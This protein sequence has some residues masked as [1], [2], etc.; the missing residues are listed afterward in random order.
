MPGG[1]G[2]AES[3][4]WQ[5]APDMGISCRQAP[6]AKTRD[7]CLGTA[8]GRRVAS[9]MG[10]WSDLQDRGCIAQLSRTASP[11]PGCKR[12]RKTSRETG[13]CWWSPCPTS[14]DVPSGTGRATSQRKLESLRRSPPQG[15]K[16]AQ[17][18]YH[19]RHQKAGHHRER[20]MKDPSEM[21]CPGFL[22]DTVANCPQLSVREWLCSEIIQGRIQRPK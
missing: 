6:R 5:S 14:C 3:Q 12:Q 18:Y 13:H 22:T 1:Y 15:Q 9:Y 17:G 8:H 10:R 19:R 16:T 7:G 21:G 4:A 11:G 2:H 20:A